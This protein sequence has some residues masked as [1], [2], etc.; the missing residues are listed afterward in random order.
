MALQHLR[1]LLPGVD[2]A[3]VDLHAGSLLGEPL[4]GLGQAQLG[5]HDVQ[6]VLRV[7]PVVDGE[8]RGQADGLAVAA[9]Q[10]RGDGME[11]AAPD[12]RAASLRAVELAEQVV[13]RGGAS[14]RPPG[15]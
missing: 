7:G 12:A 10:P 4:V 6:Q 14:L 8:G 1:E 15:G 5:A 13:R 11:G 3:A 9:E 2:A